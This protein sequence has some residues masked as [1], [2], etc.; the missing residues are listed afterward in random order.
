MRSAVKE[1][2]FLTVAVIVSLASA[3]SAT[4]IQKENVVCGNCGAENTVTVVGSSN[5]IGYSD[6]DGRPPE[7]MRSTL[8]YDVMECSKCHYCAFDLQEKPQSAAAKKVIASPMPGKTLADRFARAAEIQATEA[9]APRP[10]AQFPEIDDS[11][12]AKRNAYFAAGHL[13]LRAAWCCDDANAPER[14]VAFRRAAAKNFESVIALVVKSQE[15]IKPEFLIMLC[16]IYRRSGDFKNAER[17]ANE[18]LNY[19]S[20]PQR[21]AKRQLELCREKKTD[22][23]TLGEVDAFTPSTVID[24]GAK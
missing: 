19:K 20:L 12:Y 7:M 23:H 10:A 11:A 22:C 14:A 21:M 4:T 5:Q 17:V 6:L 24:A 16:D 3:V 9:A 15:E 1:K 18:V 2:A 13:F 8:E